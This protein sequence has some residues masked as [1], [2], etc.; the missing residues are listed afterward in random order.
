MLYERYDPYSPNNKTKYNVHCKGG[1]SGGGSS[2]QVSY[3]AYMETIH[4]T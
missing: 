2:G 1:S 3:P 4:S